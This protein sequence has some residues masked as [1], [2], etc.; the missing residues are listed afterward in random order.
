[1]S[2]ADW[3][4][5]VFLL[6]GSLLAL[7]AGIGML[8][9]PDLWTRMHAGTKPQVLGLLLVLA[10]VAVQ[11]APD[12]G[13]VVAL[14]FVGLFQL[15]TAP[16]ASH[17]LARAGHRSGVVPRDHLVQDDLRVFELECAA[18]EHPRPSGSPASAPADEPAAR[19]A[20]S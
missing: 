10:G 3:I 5:A 13:A 14:L 15:V 20:E 1:M 8:R 6:S 17:L 12:A 7:A 4:S 2:V 18:G 11:L 9:F 19:P 16:V